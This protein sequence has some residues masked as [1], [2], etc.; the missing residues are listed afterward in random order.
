MDLMSLNYTLK[1]VRMVNCMC[2][3]P[4]TKKKRHFTPRSAKSDASYGNLPVTSGPFFPF[5]GLFSSNVRIVINVRESMLVATYLPVSFLSCAWSRLSNFLEEDEF[6]I[7]WS[8][9]YSP[10]S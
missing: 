9:G 4:Q 8:P 2:I 1:M 3:S 6:Q 7:P 5:P 10:T